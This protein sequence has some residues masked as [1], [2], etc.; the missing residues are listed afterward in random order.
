MSFTAELSGTPEGGWKL[1]TN[2]L[3][4]LRQQTGRRLL[5]TFSPQLLIDHGYNQRQLMQLRQGLALSLSLYTSNP[6]LV[7]YRL[8][9]RVQPATTRLA[10]A[11]E[12][13][14]G[15]PAQEGEAAVAPSRFTEYS[16]RLIRA[17][18][19]VDPNSI[20]VSPDYGRFLAGDDSANAEHEQKGIDSKLKAGIV[21]W[22]VIG[23][24]L[25]VGIALQ[26]RRVVACCM[27]GC[28]SRRY[29][30]VLAADS[31]KFEQKQAKQA[32][33]QGPFYE[34]KQKP[35]DD[36]DHD[37]IVCQTLSDI[38]SSSS[39]PLEM[40]FPAVR[41]MTGGTYATAM[42]AAPEPELDMSDHGKPGAS[43]PNQGSVGQTIAAAGPFTLGVA[44]LTHSISAEK[45]KAA[46]AA[47]E[48]LVISSPT[49]SSRSPASPNPCDHS[50]EWSS[51]HNTSM[52][53]TPTYAGF[54][55]RTPSLISLDRYAGSPR[56]TQNA[57]LPAL[58]LLGFDQLEPVYNMVP[59]KRSPGIAEAPAGSSSSNFLAELS[60]GQLTSAPRQHKVLSPKRVSF[61]DPVVLEQPASA[62]GSD[63]SDQQSHSTDSRARDHD[64]SRPSTSVI[65]G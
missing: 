47:A 15:L 52:A 16:A 46:S 50:T 53:G 64:D 58:N 54:Q 24:V 49:S 55:P 61:C 12:A 17:G 19:P 42:A 60:S 32:H 48:K 34:P 65:F 33:V 10:A 27:C 4:Q 43:A 51:S 45:R 28:G 5:Y 21:V 7:W 39:E 30:D 3:L 6:H 1:T 41:K 13:A 37:L 44:S 23:F 25:L 63:R 26:S 29:L 59:N 38:S 2:Q 18:V 31:A 40:L 11:A 9:Q 57:Q 8:K 20:T 62:N 56:N 35:D 14:S 22:S 36:I